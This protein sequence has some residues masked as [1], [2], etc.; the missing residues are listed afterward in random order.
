[1]R[2]PGPEACACLEFCEQTE[3]VRFSRQTRGNGHEYELRGPAPSRQAAH[4]AEVQWA[5][6][7]RRAASVTTTA[8]APAEASGSSDL[9][10]SIGFW[11]LMFISLGSIIGSGWLLGALTA[12]TVAGPASL[13]SWVIGA[14]LLVVL[15]LIFAELGGRYPVAGGTARFPYFAFGTL[16]G[17]TAGWAAYLSSVATAPIE[18]EASISYLGSTHWAQQNLHLLH[19]NGTLT[20]VGLLFATGG[21]LFFTI[22]NLLGAKLL[23]ES[24]T[25]MVIWK[26][27]V[28]VLTIVVVMIL[29]FEISNFTA[30]GG[31]APYGVHG[32][33][34]AAAG[35]VCQARSQA[36]TPRCCNT[37]SPHRHPP[38]SPASARARNCS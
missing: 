15:A 24:N 9:R 18:V 6:I 21:M 16:A 27:A 20:G 11:G 1:M 30:G 7:Q 37:P 17:F 35:T 19:D 38:A 26:F 13:I 4:A 22:I 3:G 10:R 14:F 28:P 5:G 31:F 32:I 25:I 23:A 36:T 2:P 8:K 12:A 29:R 34:A 33:L